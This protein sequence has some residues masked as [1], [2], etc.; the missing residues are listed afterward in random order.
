MEKHISSMF[1]KRFRRP[2]YS[3]FAQPKG[4]KALSVLFHPEKR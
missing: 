3:G 2:D 4:N 1:K